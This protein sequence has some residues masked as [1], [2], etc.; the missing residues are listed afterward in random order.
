MKK[1]AWYICITIYSLIIIFPLLWMVSTALKSSSEVFSISPTLIPQEITFA[2]FSQV[3]QMD[4]L[5]QYMLNS[6]IV[7]IC[8]TIISVFLSCLAGYGFAKFRFRGRN[9]LLFSFLCVQMIP[10]V[11]LIAPIFGMMTEF[12]LLDSYAGLIIAHVTFTLPFCTWIM[13]AFFKGIHKELEEAAWIDGA[14]RWQAFTK[15]ILPLAMPGIISTAIFSFILSW[16]E[17]VFSLTLTRSEEMR[18]ITYGLYSFMSQY[19][20]EWNNLMA[21]SIFAIIP[22]LLIFMFLQK[23]FVKGL[24]AGSINK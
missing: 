13:T 2:S 22:P 18:T 5:K 7:A 14:T 10:S 11:V 17:F 20:V 8:S 21:A 24:L 15:I 6:L 23:Y 12:H 19:G 4:L 16:D 1:I 3:L 9:V